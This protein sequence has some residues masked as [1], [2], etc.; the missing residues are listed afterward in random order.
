MLLAVSDRDLW[1]V[2]MNL[3]SSL[4]ELCTHSDDRT[5][6]LVRRWEFSGK[7]LLLVGLAIFS[8]L[9]LLRFGRL[10]VLQRDCLSAMRVSRKS[11]CLDLGENISL[12]GFKSIALLLLLVFRDFGRVGFLSIRLRDLNFLIS[13]SSK[14]SAKQ[15]FIDGY[16][17]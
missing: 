9:S 15:I 5:V 10:D 8:V 3:L 13:N 17:Y 14:D 11:S 12:L 1:W 16:L 7:E 6:A 4:E 2:L